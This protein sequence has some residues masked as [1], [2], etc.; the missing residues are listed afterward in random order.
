[1][2]NRLPRVPAHLVSL[3]GEPVL[4]MRIDPLALQPMG[5]IK[6]VGPDDERAVTTFDLSG[7]AASLSVRFGIAPQDAPQDLPQ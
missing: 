3:S 6:P 1:M 5:R 4:R 2:E 7:V